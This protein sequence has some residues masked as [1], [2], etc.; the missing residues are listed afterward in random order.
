MILNEITFN[1]LILIHI[2]ITREFNVY[3]F[4]LLI[5]FPEYTVLKILVSI[6]MTR[7]YMVTNQTCLIFS[8][9]KINLMTSMYQPGNKIGG[10]F[11]YIKHN[12]NI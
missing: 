8:L 2:S 6:G 7:L 11:L 1:N 10:I 4:L 9:F 3:L 5:F 12:I